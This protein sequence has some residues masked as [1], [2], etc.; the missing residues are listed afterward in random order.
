MLIKEN[1]LC[2]MS[3]RAPLRTFC[4]HDYNGVRHKLASC[5]VRRCPL[6]QSFHQVEIGEHAVISEDA[7]LGVGRHQDG[8]DVFHARGI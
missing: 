1:K 5:M 4:G 2:R 7:S 8:P 3:I 6:L